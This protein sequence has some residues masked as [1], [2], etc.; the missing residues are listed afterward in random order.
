M[1]RVHGANQVTALAGLHCTGMTMRRP[2]AS[3]SCGLQVDT[4]QTCSFSSL[5][6]SLSLSLALS[7]PPPLFINYFHVIC[8][9]Q[10]ASKNGYSKHLKKPPVVCARGGGGEGAH[11]EDG[12]DGGAEELLGHGHRP[13]VCRQLVDGLIRHVFFNLFG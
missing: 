3:P 4:L 6:F 12:D 7:L 13:R 9:K 1:C 11:C 2:R 5:L 10:I 8:T